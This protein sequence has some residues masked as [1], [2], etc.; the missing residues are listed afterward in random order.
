MPN[1]S[2]LVPDGI[3]LGIQFQTISQV[4]A[5]A[6]RSRGLI[7]AYLSGIWV[8]RLGAE[9]IQAWTKYNSARAGIASGFSYLC[10]ITVVNPLSI[11]VRL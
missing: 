4:K 1:Y 2:P 8:Y 11:A 6:P 5:N 3:S 10:T 9:R 7:R